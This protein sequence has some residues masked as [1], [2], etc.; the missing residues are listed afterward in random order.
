MRQTAQVTKVVSPGYV[1]VKVKRQS[2]CAGAHNC[3]SCD[4]CALM[5]NAPEVV[6]V[7]RDERGHEVGDTVTVESETA[8]VLGA[9]VLLYIVPLALFI[10][11]YILGNTLGWSDGHAIALGGGGFL[12]GILGAM[13]LDRYYKTRPVQYRVVSV[14]G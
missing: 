8:R 5:A 14:G 12:L 9:A 3:G 4:A 13:A 7:A 11:G 6:V 1:E 10:L 2:A